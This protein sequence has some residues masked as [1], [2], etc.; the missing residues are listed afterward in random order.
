MGD[1]GSLAG[2]FDGGSKWR[3]WP[4]IGGQNS[5]TLQVTFAGK[6]AGW[7]VARVVGG[8]TSLWRTRDGGRAW[9]KA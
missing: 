2:P 8:G 1:R 9:S 7:A 4:R 5:G 6:Q 3:T